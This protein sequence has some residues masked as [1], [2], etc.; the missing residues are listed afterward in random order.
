MGLGRL[1]RRRG[2]PQPDVNVDYLGTD[3]YIYLRSSVAASAEDFMAFHDGSDNNVYKTAFR[4]MPGY[5]A[6]FVMQADTGTNQV[7][8]N[9]N[10]RF[11]DGVEVSITVSGTLKQPFYLSSNNGWRQ[12]T[13]TDVRVSPSNKYPLD[14]TFG[15]GGDGT[16]EW[17]ING[18]VKSN[19]LFASATFDSSSFNISGGFGSGNIK[20]K[21]QVTIGT[22]QLEVINDYSI[23]AGD[24]FIKV[25]TTVK[26][27]GLAAVTNLRYWV[28][29][30][31]DYVGG[32]DE[33]IKER[34]NLVNG[35]FQKLTSITQRSSALRILTLD[36]GILF[37][38][39]ST[40]ANTSV[41][42]FDF[43]YIPGL[44]L[45]HDTSHTCATRLEKDEL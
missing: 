20:V 41:A 17:N 12:L 27:I 2:G 21:G 3:N 32:T 37:F 19:P 39:K 31:D 18:V 26:N 25:T 35:S 14:C 24:N 42:D 44:R 28:G 22:S 36:E 15:V 45:L 16:N 11:G 7:I 43:D 34:G 30:R 4:D 6:N 1:A 40:S 5:Y 33:P 23:G 29:T 13:Y 8:N 38:T 10:M 9:G